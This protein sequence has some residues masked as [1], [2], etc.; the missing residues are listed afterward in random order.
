M[1]SQYDF[2]IRKRKYENTQLSEDKV[3]SYLKTINQVLVDEKLYKVQSLTLSELSKKSSISSKY[4]SQVINQEMG[5]SFSE[6]LLQLRINEAK[7]NL[8]NTELKHLSIAGIGS[9]SGFASSSR[10]NHQF[11]KIT[12]M[13]PSEYQKSTHQHI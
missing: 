10:F 11:K 3:T 9:E 4:I 13:T 2:G 1:N 6:Y 12:G 8:L 5:I 7:I